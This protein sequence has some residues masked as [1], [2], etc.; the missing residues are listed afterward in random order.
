LCLVA[1]SPL[2]SPLLFAFIRG[3]LRRLGVHSRFFCGRF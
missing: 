2:L 1:D 3:Y